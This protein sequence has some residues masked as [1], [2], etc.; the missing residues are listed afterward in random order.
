MSVSCTPLE[1]L[2]L[3]LVGRVAAWCALVAISSTL[4]APFAVAQQAQSQSAF[5]Q[6][7]L[8]VGLGDDVCDA[9]RMAPDTDAAL[10]ALDL[11]NAQRADVAAVLNR[12]QGFSAPPLPLAAFDSA[13]S[14]LRGVSSSAPVVFATARSVST[15]PTPP[16]L[17]ADA[18][19]EIDECICS[20]PAATGSSPRAP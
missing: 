18:L 7:C 11:S 13:R 3:A 19:A 1:S 9:L 20:R 16:T 5:D 14:S 4:G 17:G 15:V 12:T 10:A 2:R 8:Q 6:V